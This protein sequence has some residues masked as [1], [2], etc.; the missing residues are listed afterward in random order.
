MQT[1]KHLKFAR[2]RLQLVYTLVIYHDTSKQEEGSP[3]RL[4]IVW[5]P[6]PDTMKAIVREITLHQ[7]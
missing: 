7:L 5:R 2:L 4:M 3:T 6:L 1:V